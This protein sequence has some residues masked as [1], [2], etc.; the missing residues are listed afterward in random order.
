MA[1]KRQSAGDKKR[2]SRCEKFKPRSDFPRNK[3]LA[4]GLGAYCRPCKRL[5]DREQRRPQSARE[6]SPPKARRGAEKLQAPTAE[7]LTVP[8]LPR[9]PRNTLTPE[10]VERICE[11][12]RSGH[13]RRVAARKAGINE[14]TLAVWMHRGRES[15]D[16]LA[17]TRSLYDAVLEA[18]GIGLG[19]LE[20]KALAGAEIDHVQ[21]LRLLKRRDPETWARRE[22]KAEANDPNQMEIDDVRKLLTERL[23]RFLDAAAPA[24]SPAVTPESGAAGGAGS[25]PS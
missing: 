12:L 24:A 13:S 10:L 23:N 19:S 8:P 11:P 6:E 3:T 5:A 1:A 2:C 15:K 4:D 20:E 17:P 7:I 9:G 22:V 18:E 25:S 14:D 21:A 16:P